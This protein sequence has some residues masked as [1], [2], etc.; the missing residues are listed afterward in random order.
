MNSTCRLKLHAEIPLLERSYFT[1][2]PKIIMANGMLFGKL[3]KVLAL[4]SAVLVIPVLAFVGHGIGNG[5]SDKKPGNGNGDG[6]GNGNGNDHGNPPF[7][8]V[9]E[10]N[11]ALVLIPFFGAVV[12][13]SSLHVM[14]A[15]SA[16]KNST[17][18]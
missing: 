8:T 15:K 12:L 17:R 7:S 5:D 11:S 14:R 4:G 3:G 10:A 2:T 16:Q 18:S 1:R 6:N 9:P 13:F